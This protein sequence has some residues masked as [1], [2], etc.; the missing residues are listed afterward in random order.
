MAE[1]KEAAPAAAVMTDKWILKNLEERSSRAVP[2]KANGQCEMLFYV[3]S[4]PHKENFPVQLWVN[5]PSEIYMQG[6][7]AFNAKGVVLGSNTEEFWFAL[8]PK[9][10]SSCWWGLWSQQSSLGTMMINPHVVLEGMGIMKIDSEEQW[11]FGQE[12]SY[13]VLT[14][15]DEG[16]TKRIYVN[17]HDGRIRRMEYVGTEGEAVTVAELDKYTKLAEDFYVPTQVKIIRRLTSDKA[18][19]VSITLK[20]SSVKATGFT[21]EQKQFLFQRRPMQGFK[22]IYRIIDSKVVEQQQE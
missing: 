6:D 17:R 12:D 22:H 15:Q 16:R 11:T 18:G 7:V 1:Q 2:L 10:I 21:E 19:F 20:I 5:P 3:K 13:R 9:E 4:K 8:Q 14:R